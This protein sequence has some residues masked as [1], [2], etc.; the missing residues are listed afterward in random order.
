MME[1][2]IGMIFDVIITFN[3]VMEDIEEKNAV[4][5]SE[6]VRKARPGESV[7]TIFGG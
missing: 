2:D 5:G 4:T 7:R 3:N 1:M 6:N